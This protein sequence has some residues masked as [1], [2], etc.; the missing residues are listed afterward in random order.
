MIWE[1]IGSCFQHI[2]KE[3][4]DSFERPERMKWNAAIWQYAITVN[5]I[6]RSFDADG[7]H[8]LT[9]AFEDESSG[10]NS[11]RK[12]WPQFFRERAKAEG[13]YGFESNGDN[14]PPLRTGIERTNYHIV[15]V[16][17]SNLT[18]GLHCSPIWGG[19]SCRHE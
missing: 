3:I 11:Q 16:L 7:D 2:R 10:R 15:F 8:V 6:L 12:P 18:L 5:F 13:L 1:I 19:V 17:N 4:V 9:S 14:V